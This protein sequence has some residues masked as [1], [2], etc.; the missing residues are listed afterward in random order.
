MRQPAADASK[1]NNCVLNSSEVYPSFD[2]VPF[3]FLYDSLDETASGKLR[4]RNQGHWNGIDIDGRKG[5]YWAILGQ[6]YQ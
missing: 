6:C 3:V 5:G 1:V 4:N 2:F